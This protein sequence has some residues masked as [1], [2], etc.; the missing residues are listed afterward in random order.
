MTDLYFQ[1]PAERH[2][3]A[4]LTAVSDPSVAC[5]ARTGLLVATHRIRVLGGRLRCGHKSGVVLGVRSRAGE[6]FRLRER[7][8]PGNH[9]RLREME[10]S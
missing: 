5:H 4:S 6:P 3:G 10:L 1:K 2:L 7:V 9:K 8:L